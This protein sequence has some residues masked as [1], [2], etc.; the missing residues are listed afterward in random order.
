M[1]RY[2]GCVI[3]KM[4]EEGVVRKIKDTK[5]V[6]EIERNPACAGCKLCRQHDKK[7]MHIELDNSIGARVSDKVL[8]H[9]DDAV[10]LKGAAIVYALP[11][12]GLLSGLFGGYFLARFIGFTH[13]K[14]IFAVGGALIFLTISLFII[15]RFDLINKEKFQPT[16]TLAGGK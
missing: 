15:R 5:I 10:I 11:L 2:P 6:V 12:L 13:L 4:V 7:L 16:V 3:I 8:L 1:K 14:E 9:M